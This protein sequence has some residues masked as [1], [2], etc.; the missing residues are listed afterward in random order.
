MKIL[1]FL[2]Q[3]LEEEI[4]KFPNKNPD[5]TFLEIGSGSGIQ[6]ETLLKLGIKKQNIF[7]CDVNSHSVKH[8]KSFGF[9]CVYSNLFENVK[10]RFDIIIFNPPYL[11]EDSLEPLNSRISTTG[12]KKGSEVI[13]EFLRQA[14]HHLNK[15][16]SVIVV[17]KTTKFIKPF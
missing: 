17:I 3:I 2:T 15:D 6:L 11:S 13:N 5:L 16:G 9:N 8:C 10:D 1:I 14:R 12:G 4:S 7:S